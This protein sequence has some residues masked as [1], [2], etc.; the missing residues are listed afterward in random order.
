MEAANRF[1]SLLS[2]VFRSHWR[3]D[4]QGAG[5]RVFTTWAVPADERTDTFGRGIHSSTFQPQ[6]EPFLSPTLKPPIVTDATQRS[7]QKV[8]TVILKSGRV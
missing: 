4:G 7:L 6:P 2:N 3:V 1:D 8:L 5:G